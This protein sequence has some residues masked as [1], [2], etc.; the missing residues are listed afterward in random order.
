MWVHGDSIK[1]LDFRVIHFNVFYKGLKEAPLFG[2]GFIQKLNHIYT[3]Y[4]PKY[5]CLNISV[6]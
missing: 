6:N 4:I 2:D 3:K 1:H 5:C